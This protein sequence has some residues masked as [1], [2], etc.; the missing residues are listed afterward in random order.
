MLA[1]PEPTVER[2]RKSR[3]ARRKAIPKVIGVLQDMGARVELL[4]RRANHHRLHFRSGW[5]V[6]FWP[7]TERWKEPKSPRGGSGLA[8]LIAAISQHGG[9]R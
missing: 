9:R 4:D 3:R 6:D 7:T 1:Q 2:S 8:G 5:V